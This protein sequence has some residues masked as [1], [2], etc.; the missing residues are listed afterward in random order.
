MSIIISGVGGGGGGA[1]TLSGLTD[2]TIA[3][4][5]GGQILSY[6]NVS[7]QW[8]N[9]TG[10]TGGLTYKGS[11]NATTGAPSIATLFKVISMSSLSRGRSTARRGTSAITS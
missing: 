8:E 3:A 9:Q 7:G 4:L 10:I 11:F 5:A 2:V 1:T 6:N